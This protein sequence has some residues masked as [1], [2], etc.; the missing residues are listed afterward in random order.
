MKRLI[1][2]TARGRQADG[3]DVVLVEAEVLREPN[4]G[5]VV[6]EFRV[7]VISM[8]NNS[9]EEE[10]LKFWVTKLPKAIGI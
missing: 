4:Q 2:Q 5:D 1:Q 9:I 3:L 10:F 7:V 8:G 6:R